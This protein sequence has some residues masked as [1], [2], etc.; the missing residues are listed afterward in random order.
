MAKQLDLSVPRPDF[1]FDKAEEWAVKAKQAA[2]DL[3]AAG[4]RLRAGV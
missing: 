4:V 2:G 3:D 1:P